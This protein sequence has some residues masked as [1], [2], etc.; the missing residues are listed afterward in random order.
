MIKVSYYDMSYLLTNQ[1]IK[2]ALP[3]W[4]S[5]GVYYCVRLEAFLPANYKWASAPDE[6]VGFEVFLLPTENS[7]FKVFKRGGVYYKKANGKEKR[8]YDKKSLDKIKDSLIPQEE[9]YQNRKYLP[10]P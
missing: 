9:Y 3:V 8:P 5:K 2:E 1:E 10:A 7:F 6:D 4:N